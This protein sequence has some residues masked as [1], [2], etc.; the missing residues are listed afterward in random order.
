VQQYF[1]TYRFTNTVVAGALGAGI[2]VEI[3]PFGD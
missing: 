2:V 3:S 1:E